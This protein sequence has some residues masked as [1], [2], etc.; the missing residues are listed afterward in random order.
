MGP[1]LPYIVIN[2]VNTVNRPP[3][4]RC[5]CGVFVACLFML[6]MRRRRLFIAARLLFI[7]FMLL[8]LF[9]L[10]MLFMLLCNNITSASR[11]YLAVLL[12]VG[13][14]YAGGAAVLP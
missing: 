13:K 1:G 8:C 14:K 11:F 2:T 12:H 7:L 4:S 6:F 3:V 9:M 5:F 10:F